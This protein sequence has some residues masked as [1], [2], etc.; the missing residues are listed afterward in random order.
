[1]G[2]FY[3]CE[4]NGDKPRAAI[5]WQMVTLWKKPS[6]RTLNVYHCPSYIKANWSCDSMARDILETS[7]A[8]SSTS[9]Y[10]PRVMAKVSEMVAMLGIATWMVDTTL[11]NSW[12]STVT[13][14]ELSGFFHQPYQAV[15][16]T[17]GREYNTHFL[18][19]SDSFL[20]SLMLP[21][22]FILFDS[23]HSSWG[24]QAYWFP[25]GVGIP[26]PAHLQHWFDYSNQEAE[27]T[28]RGLTL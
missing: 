5:P 28:G 11:F 2:P 9:W 18:Q 20:Y 6:G 19:F 21:R 3:W 22:Q 17:M 24:W 4:E 8:K 13:H 12:W 14:R 1:M 15:E 16:S 23:Y 26:H 25:S 7:F 10:T 27:F